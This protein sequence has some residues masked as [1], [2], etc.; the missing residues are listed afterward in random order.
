[1][2]TTSMSIVPDNFNK[3]PPAT[4]SAPRAAVT[5]SIVFANTGFA[6]AQS[7]KASAFSITKSSM[8]CNGAIRV[9]IVSPSILV[10]ALNLSSS[11]VKDIRKLDALERREQKESNTP[12]LAISD[13]MLKNTSDMLEICC[14]GVPYS[15][16]V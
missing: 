14:I 1:M 5:M 10:I 15:C 13:I 4:K 3:V 9:V 12:L 8:L 2:E 16:A 7:R 6:C 11:S